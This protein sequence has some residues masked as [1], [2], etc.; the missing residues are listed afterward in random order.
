MEKGYD[1][2]YLFIYLFASSCSEFLK[3]V[4]LKLWN[5]LLKVKD[6]CDSLD[7]GSYT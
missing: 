1:F 7:E 2:T 5:A 4:P 6:A 3:A